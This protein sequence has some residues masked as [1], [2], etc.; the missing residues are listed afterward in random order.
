MFHTPDTE[1][2]RLCSILSSAAFGLVFAL[3][4]LDRRGERYYLHWSASALIYS[5]VLIGFGFARGHALL[6]STLLAALAGTNM[7]IVSGLRAFDGKPSF[8]WWMT[9]PVAACFVVHLVAPMAARDPKHAFIAT[10]IGD[11]LSV[12]LS[13]LI[14]GV[15]CLRGG[16]QDAGTPGARPWVNRGRRLAGFAMLG[17]LPC[18]AI[19][20]AGYLWT[21]SALNLLALIP[22]MSDQLLLGILNLGLLAIPAEHAQQR[23]S[24]A[25]LRDPLTGVWNRAGF[26]S[27]SMRLIAPGATVL[28][29]DLD[30]FK[31]INDRH[32]HLMGDDVLVALARLAGSEV[33][34]L[35]GE[36]GRLG[37]DEFIALLPKQR[38]PDAETCARQIQDAC[39]RYADGMPEWTISMGISQI[40]PGERDLRAALQRA[41]RALYRAKVDGRDKVI[42]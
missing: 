4:F 18:Y 36:F 27:Q 3:L 28:A 17:Y 42:A 7:L 10:Q 8:R 2:V 9:L 25:A 16:S 39:R 35:D 33:A 29:I 41:D 24:D 30:H 38:T 40:H 11:T 20:V 37:G 26:E 15:I 22:T 19:T 34:S 6:M 13:M 31:Q 12:A 23:L 1:T 32:G 14:A 21:N 5:A